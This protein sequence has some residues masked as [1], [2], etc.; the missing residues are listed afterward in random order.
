MLLLLLFFYYNICSPLLEPHIE[1]KKDFSTSDAEFSQDSMEALENHRDLYPLNKYSDGHK[2]RRDCSFF[3]SRFA[4][5]GWLWLI[6]LLFCPVLFLL[7]EQL[8]FQ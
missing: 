4:N 5:V 7:I 1:E 8:M 3:A 6:S 2:W